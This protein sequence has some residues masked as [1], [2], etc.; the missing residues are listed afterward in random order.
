[1][2][3]MERET[4]G[5]VREEEYGPAP[6]TPKVLGVQ[7][8]SE[9]RSIGSGSGVAHPG[10]YGDGEMV[11]EWSRRACGDTSPVERGVVESL[12]SLPGR[13]KVRGSDCMKKE[14]VGR[15]G[16]GGDAADDGDMNDVLPWGVSLAHAVEMEAN[17]GE[18]VSLTSRTVV[19]DGGGGGKYE[20]T[21]MKNEE[22]NSVMKVIT[23]KDNKYVAATTVATT[24]TA[25]EAVE[26]DNE[27]EEEDEGGDGSLREGGK[28]RVAA[29]WTTE[30]D[31]LLASLV[32]GFVHSK[33]W[34]SLSRQMPG[35]N[36][37]QCRERWNNHL[38]PGV[39]TGPFSI[40][41]D[42]L[43]VK[44][45]AKFG[46][47]WAKIRASMPK[48]GD[49]SIKNRWNSSL[50]KKVEKLRQDCRK[51]QSSARNPGLQLEV[52]Q[53]VLESEGIPSDIAKKSADRMHQEHLEFQ[54]LKRQRICL[55]SQRKRM[56]LMSKRNHQENG[57]NVSPA[58]ATTV[59]SRV[60]Y[61]PSTPKRKRLSSVV[62]SDRHSD[63]QQRY[64][65][66]GRKSQLSITPCKGGGGT[67]S[68]A[69]TDG[70]TSPETTPGSDSPYIHGSDWSS[71]YKRKSSLFL[72]GD[73]SS[74]T[75]NTPPS[76]RRK[77][78]CTPSRLS[79]EKDMNSVDD[80]VGCGLSTL[81]AASILSLSMLRGGRA[82]AW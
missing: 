28:R 60:K 8:K 21:E 62:G 51:H 44:L 11:I 12:L 20:G 57:G 14:Y 15:R 47:K 38:D 81:E 42:C 2:P 56:Y 46:N 54:E 71:S 72:D 74:S 32:S 78:N 79:L 26:E 40:E 13:G 25:D 29:P 16:G 23:E 50:K 68:D 53:T 75:I 31:A 30:E 17:N 82:A 19:E 76:R 7:N 55:V 22:E 59:G 48:R 37:K 69:P 58:P 39:N 6:H 18:K 67:V 80:F 41:E 64:I 3:G 73:E 4:A 36:G 70:C 43:I 65:N 5:G 9:K 49:N 10:E 66:T 1:M 45:Q 27:E 77:R 33:R 63:K 35:R 24:A 34:A 52:I 61:R